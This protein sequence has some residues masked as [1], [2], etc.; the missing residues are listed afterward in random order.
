M[1]FNRKARILNVEKVD[2][3]YPLIISYCANSNKSFFFFKKSVKRK[4]LIIQNFELEDWN[5]YGN[6]Q[7][8]ESKHI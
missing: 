7:N 8:R 1:N 2:K 3:Y 4:S 5:I 6:N